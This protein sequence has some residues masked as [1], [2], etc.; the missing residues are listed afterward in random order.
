MLG[1]KDP[2]CTQILKAVLSL[3]LVSV[4]ISQTVTSQGMPR[5][6]NCTLHPGK[7]EESIVPGVDEA[8]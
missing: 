1:R 5:M 8:A 6:V 3:Q 4:E 7:T 2:S